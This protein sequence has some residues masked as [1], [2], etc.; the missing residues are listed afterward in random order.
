[1]RIVG[2]RSSGCGEG[3]SDAKEWQAWLDIKAAGP[4][5]LEESAEIQRGSPH[6][7]VPSTW[8]R[9]KKKKYI[10]GPGTFQARSQLVVQGFKDPSLGQCRSDAPAKSRLAEALMLS[11]VATLRMHLVCGDSTNAYLS[12]KPIGRDVYIKQPRG[13][14]PLV[15][16]DVLLKVRSAASAIY[17]ISEAARLFCLALKKAPEEDG[18]LQ[19]KLEPALFY[20][21]D[22]VG[23]LGI[24]CTH[25]D[26]VVCGVC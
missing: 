21:Y 12:G 22:E 19:S 24:A 2:A 25:V 26:D 10:S 18:W 23:M 9:A 13:G 1:M 15:Q 7:I 20:K 16:A 14:L 11:L 4:M 3:G 17:G 8:L 5:S 6:L